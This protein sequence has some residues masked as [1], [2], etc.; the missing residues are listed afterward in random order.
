V[1]KKHPA[2]VP[3]PV[4]GFFPSGFDSL[5]GN[6]SD[7]RWGLGVSQRPMGMMRQAWLCVAGCTRGSDEMCG[8]L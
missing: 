1:L 6:A 2:T 5:A 8:E 7:E 4:P 3:E